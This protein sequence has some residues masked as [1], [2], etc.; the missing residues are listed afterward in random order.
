VLQALKRFFGKRHDLPTRP[1]EPDLTPE[2]EAAAREQ[3]GEE[4]DEPEA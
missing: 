3:R 2:E 1:P 4:V